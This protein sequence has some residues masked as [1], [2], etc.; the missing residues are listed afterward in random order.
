VAIVLAVL[1]PLV[2]FT[3]DVLGPM[4]AFQAGQDTRRRLDELRLAFE[5][6]YREHAAVV[7]GEAEAVFRLPSGTVRATAIDGASGRC[8]G[9]AD[10]FL[11]LARWLASASSVAFRDGHGAPL[12]VFITPRRVQSVSGVDLHHRILA[13]VSPGPNGRPDAGAGCRTGLGEDGRLTLCGDDEGLRIDGQAIAADHLARTLARMQVAADAYRGH[14]QARALADAARDI[15]IDYFATA[16]SPAG[17]W[18]VGGGIG[19]AGCDG[20]APRALADGIAATLGLAPT[21]A[22]DAWG[23]ALRIDNCSDAV[24]SPRHPDAVRQLPPYTAAIVA[25]LPGP[26]ELRVSVLGGL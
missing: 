17:R 15:A 8:L 21:D 20:V 5:A 11:P 12:C 7:D 22:V 3:L 23:G 9:D 10:T 13:I 1:M 26:V 18:D 19:L 16:S 2:L 14:F 24:R 25:T 6:A 4:L